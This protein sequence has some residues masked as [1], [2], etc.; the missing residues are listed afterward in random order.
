MRQNYKSKIIKKFKQVIINVLFISIFSN[1]YIL[2]LKN[3]DYTKEN[4]KPLIPDKWI[5]I[6]AFNPPSSFIINLE[7]NI[8]DWKI[9]VI[10]NNETNDI[11]W[12]IFKSS[13]KLFY[14]SL[15]DQID[16]N[17]NIIKYLKQNSYYRKSI[18][19]LYA[20]QHGAKEIYE[21]DEDI[22][23]NNFSCINNYFDDILVSYVKRND[24]LMIN[25]YSHF[26]DKN[27]W[28]R[29]FKISDIGKQITNDFHFINSSNIL[30]K[31]LIFQG[32]IN[33]YPDVDSL[34]YLTRKDLNS[35]YNFN[36]SYP[37]IYFPNNY[38]PI[39]SKNTRYLYDIFPLL[40]FPI[41]ID[42]NIG[43]I[44][45]GYIMQYFSW[46]MNGVIIYYSS[47]SFRKINPT[48]N[49]DFTTQKKIFIELNKFLE[50]LN[51]CNNYDKNKNTL[52][53]YINF[54]DMLV[55][56]KII[57]G[58]DSIVYKMFSKDLVNIGYNFTSFTFTETKNDHSNYFKIDSMF[59]LYIPSNL[60]IIKNNNLNLMNHFFS[61]EV[62]DDILLIVNFN[63]QGF[64]FLKDYIINLYNK[65]FPN[66]IFIYPSYTK[67]SNTVICKESYF[68]F[69][70]YKCFKKVYNKYP[71]YKGYLYINDDLFLKTWE[72][73]NLDFSIPWLNQYIPLSEE[74]WFHH[75]RCLPLYYLLRKNSKWKNNFLGFNGYFDV[76][77]GMS[78]FYYLPNFYASKI[79]DILDKMYKYRIF[80]ECAIPNSF[81]ILHAHKYQII[82]IYPLWE[83]EREKA[84]DYLYSKYDQISFH[85]LKLSNEE[86]R[87]KLSQYIFFISACDY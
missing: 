24:S 73:L 82:D 58:E 36:R 72:L 66:I 32:L 23:F 77:H 28:P 7:K 30:L 86:S 14:L 47:D 85:P 33:Y 61:D 46:K 43:D 22:E 42:E 53:I 18:G 12:N 62:Y 29:G 55:D 17:Y 20:I 38:V 63:K 54:L 39:N 64:L 2:F 35:I 57:N 13:N 59:H 48:K 15:E 41:S 6:T 87:R 75:S 50:L 67:E 56:N 83:I 78:D 44:W 9:I 26:G 10:G 37:L 79:G 16:L 52:E 3:K 84:I 80:L 34:F 31:P 11:K 68:G 60:S 49:S 74:N 4:K 5:V 81:G 69:Y 65:Y 21:I 25:P 19:Y 1:T 76:V 51:S 27:I 8:E 71:N 40:M 70:S 45:R